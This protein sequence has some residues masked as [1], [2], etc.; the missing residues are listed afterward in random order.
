MLLLA[1]T[2]TVN[3]KEDNVSAEVYF[4]FLDVKFKYDTYRC[5]WVVLASLCSQYRT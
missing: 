1:F 5:I 4:N 3:Y 2:R